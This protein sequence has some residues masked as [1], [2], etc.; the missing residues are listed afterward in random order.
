MKIVEITEALTAMKPGSW[1]VMGNML[2][3]AAMQKLTGLDAGPA[4]PAQVNAQTK[5][6]T[7]KV[8]QQMIQTWPQSV[9]Q[10]MQNS[11]GPRGSRGVTNFTKVSKPLLL[12]EL[13]R[14]VDTLVKS[15]TGNR[16]TSMNELMTINPTDA[17]IQ[18]QQAV[19]EKQRI[20][21]LSFALLS[22]TDPSAKPDFAAKAWN[23]IV[24]AIVTISQ[25]EIGSQDPEE[26][27][28]R[29]AKITKDASGKISV[30]G[31]ILNMKDA[32]DQ[33]TLT[34][35]NALGLIP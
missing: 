5:A 17:S 12:G 15:L 4:D 10:I 2:K 33:Q 16:Y 11:P 26:G 27:E 7:D 28:L 20:L 19:K 6:V 25:S 22:R 21:N 24:N 29:R 34:K 23:G 3:Q 18:S 31:R 8:T 30:N 32:K 35:I 9:L 1:A 13:T 14:Q